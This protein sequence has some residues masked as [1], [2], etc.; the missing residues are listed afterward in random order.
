M[1]PPPVAYRIDQ[2]G[3]RNAVAFHAMLSTGFLLLGILAWSVPYAIGAFDGARLAIAAMAAGG[4]TLFFWIAFRFFERLRS[5]APL[6]V[7]DSQGVYDNGSA[8]FSGV[9]WIGW[10]EIEDVRVGRYHRLPCVE[11]VLKDRDRFL[12]RVPW[13]G[14]VGRSARLGYPAVA[15]RGPLL[16]GDPQRLVEQIRLYARSVSTGQF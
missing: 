14:R 13:S 2:R 15:F 7:L 16:P 5:D 6:F 3:A 12:E 9:G 10:G 8:V 11:L 1:Q 4:A